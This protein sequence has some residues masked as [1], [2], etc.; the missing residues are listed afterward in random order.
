MYKHRIVTTSYSKSLLEAAKW[1][2]EI[3]TK[4]NDNTPFVPWN[5]ASYL[6]QQIEHEW[7]P[8]FSDE[9]DDETEAMMQAEIDEVPTPP[10]VG[11]RL[12]G[13]HAS[14]MIEDIFHY[15]QIS[16]DE[17][18]FSDS[19]DCNCKE[20][21]NKFLYAVAIALH[22]LAACINDDEVCVEIVSFHE[23]TSMQ[24]D[25]LTD[26]TT[27]RQRYVKAGRSISRRC[28][29]RRDTQRRRRGGTTTD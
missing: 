10:K 18:I 9:N 28:R 19:H 12:T 17:F 7:S 2:L 8:Y 23:I 5:T 29:P 15:S 20:Q 6:V 14:I 11:I 27:D 21:S 25:A 24:Q 22:R 1:L 16:L 3:A 4:M 26:W 13:R